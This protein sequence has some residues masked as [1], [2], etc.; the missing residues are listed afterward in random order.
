[1]P[2]QAILQVL[3]HDFA[4]YELFGEIFRADANP[5]FVTTGSQQGCRYEGK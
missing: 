5:W 2:V 4:E 3:G 1:M